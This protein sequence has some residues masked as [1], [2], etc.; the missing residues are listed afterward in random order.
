MTSARLGLAHVNGAF[1]VA[2][3]ASQLV[4]CLAHERA[5]D[6]AGAVTDASG[7]CG[8]GA[9]CTSGNH[10]Y[11]NRC[12]SL[13]LAPGACD[14]PCA[15]A[16]HGDLCTEEGRV[17][18]SAP[19]TSLV[20]A[21]GNFI[22]VGAGCDASAG[23]DAGADSGW[24]ECPAPPPGCVY[25]GTPCVCS[26]MTC[27]PDC[28]PQDAHSNGRCAGSPGWA[29]D[30]TACRALS[31]SCVG[32]ECDAI[33]PSESDCNA[34]FS[35]CPPPDCHTDD[36]VG[37]GGCAVVIGYGFTS[38]GC[39]PVSGCSCTGADC[40]TVTGQSETAC[41]DAHASCPILFL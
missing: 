9:P 25:D 36:A 18:S 39:L 41:N 7:G 3:A 11:C 13:D 19:C 37:V 1:F 34:Y 28:T 22:T 33:F 20:C 6:D 2:L 12:I 29:W 30:G 40:A 14:P 15:T 38:R 21:S 32:T 8:G 35:A 27:T 17:C 23:D 31:C 16:R 10:C 5:A 4:G 26:H 24:C